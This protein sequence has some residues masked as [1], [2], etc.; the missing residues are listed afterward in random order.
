[1]LRLEAPTNPMINM[2]VMTGPMILQPA[3]GFV[4]DRMW[5]GDLAAGVRVYDAAAYRSGFSI[6][7]AWI[8]ISF[9]L[10]IFTRETYCRQ[11]A[12]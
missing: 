7:L 6:M 2:G 12:A 11:T 3:V 10:L 4:L 8:V 9:I 5:R 1:M